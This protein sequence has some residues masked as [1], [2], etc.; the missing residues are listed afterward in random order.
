MSI[1]SISMTQLG[2]IF[3]REIFV[4]AGR[5]K[6]TQ[7]RTIVFLCSINTCHFSC[8]C[9]D[10]VFWICKRPEIDPVVFNRDVSDFSFN[11]ELLVC[12]CILGVKYYFQFD[13]L[14]IL[15]K[16]I[17]CASILFYCNF[18]FIGRSKVYLNFN[19]GQVRRITSLNRFLEFL[20]DLSI[21]PIQI[22]PIC[23]TATVNFTGQNHW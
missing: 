15:M 7:H 12:W 16:W 17:I 4:Y 22:K 10:I 20:S 2:H 13:T 3:F 1:C 21:K 23:D 19:G 8:R 18:I 11:Q 14:S 9:L 6:A 5:N